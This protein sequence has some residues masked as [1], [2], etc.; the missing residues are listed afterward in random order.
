MAVPKVMYQHTLTVVVETSM[1]AEAAF[2]CD[3]VKNM[4]GPWCTELPCVQ[5]NNIE[6]PRTQTSPVAKLTYS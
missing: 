2:V 4:L 3:R 6:V 1:P 5:K